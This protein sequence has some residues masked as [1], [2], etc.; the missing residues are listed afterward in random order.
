MKALFISLILVFVIVTGYSQTKIPVSKIKKEVKSINNQ[1]TTLNCI[2]TEHS[3]EDSTYGILITRYSKYFNTE[4]LKKG[5][6]L[7]NSN[8]DTNMLVKEELYFLNNIL[9]YAKIYEYSTGNTIEVY[10]SSNTYFVFKVN[11]KVVNKM[12]NEIKYIIL[13][14]LSI[15]INNLKK[16]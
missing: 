16:F 6:I 11:D 14:Q 3:R 9:I 13:T 15:D 4:S 8:T 7:Y 12:H 5:E 10:V 2:T 1:L